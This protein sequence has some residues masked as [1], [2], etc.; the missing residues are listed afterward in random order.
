[1][2]EHL[3]QYKG[4]H[5]GQSGE[6]TTLRDALLA[7]ALTRPAAPTTFANSFSACI[8]THSTNPSAYKKE[9]N[10]GGRQTYLLPI[11]CLL[12]FVLE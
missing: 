3:F 7:N 5:P 10:I 12:A 8:K 4:Y 6:T 1:M 2:M 11:A 9:S